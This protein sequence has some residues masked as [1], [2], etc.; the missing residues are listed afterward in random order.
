MLYRIPCIPPACL[1][2]LLIE[3][4]DSATAALQKKQYAAPKL[5]DLDIEEAK[6]FLLDEAAHGD[7]EAEE[8]LNSLRQT[9]A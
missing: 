8:L 4:M 1:S 3:P 6:I 5:Q 7:K 9:S 2:L